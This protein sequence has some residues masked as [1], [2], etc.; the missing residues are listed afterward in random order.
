MEDKRTLLAFLLIGLILLLVPYYSDWMG[1]SPHKNTPKIPEQ[2][3]STDQSVQELPLPVQ[4]PVESI[5]SGQKTLSE[6]FSA[7]DSLFTPRDI[8][9]RTPLQKL[10][11]ST[12]GGIL[13]SAQL[14][15]YRRIDGREVELVPSGGKGFAIYLNRL[16]VDED[17]SGI[18]FIP[19]KQELIISEG[20]KGNLRF[21]ANLTGGRRL[22]RA[23]T[24]YSDRYGFDMDIA[25]HG[26]DEDTEAT[27]VWDKGIPLT[28]KIPQTDIDQTQCLAYFNES[29]TKIQV[30]SNAEKSWEDKGA[31]KWVG[32]RNM[33]FLSALVLQSDGRYS[34]RLKGKRTQ[35]NFI[36]DYSYEVGTRLNGEGPWKNQVYLGP[37]NYDELIRYQD[38]LEQAIDFG[39]PVVRQISRFLLV[40]FK[41]AYRFIP[42]YG[43]IIVLFAVA[44]KILVYP[45][46]RKTFESTSKMQEIQPKIAALREKYK[47]DQ[48][49][50]SR[51]TMKLYK[52]EGVN[53]LGGCLPLLLQ[54]PVFFALYNLFGRTIELRQA[55]FIFW[56]KDLSLPDE[57]I[58]AGYG[59]HVLPF[60]MALSMLVQQKMTMK[61]P[62]Q[63]FMVYAMPVV[64]IFIF[65]KMTSGLVLYWTVFNLLT[66]GQQLLVDF[67]KKPALVQR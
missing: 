1:I 67:F 62:K 12:A 49:R 11:F 51:E 29:L 43:W 34:A 64:M 14:H 58:V 25:F 15:K 4:S 21:A 33:Y 6:A 44:I 42:N 37:L 41:A 31:L 60:L 13:L 24:F 27:L 22:E 39:W 47:N 54:M 52:E 38:D 10:T 16:G 2:S 19:D 26:F 7:V 28:E 36:P 9:V 65:W 8:T 18:E 32:V 50:L 23:L 57:I 5:S 66:I 3:N 53:P 45:L 46:T 63:A 56:I 48:Q 61:D 35:Q 55:P 30:G 20:E 17:L 59:I 40:L